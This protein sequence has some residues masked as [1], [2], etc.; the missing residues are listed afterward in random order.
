MAKKRDSEV[1]RGPV[2]VAIVG[3]GCA[4]IAAAWELSKV[5]GYEVEVFEKSW[6][7]GGKGASGRDADGH[8]QEHGLH[9]WLGFYENA[10]RMIR[11]CYAE[12]EQRQ[13][14][15]RRG[16]PEN[17]LAH[18]SWDDAF[19]AEPH[20]G[21]AIPHGGDEWLVW[22][23]LLPPSKGLPGD[24]FDEDSNPFTLANYLVRC[25]ELLRALMLS[26]IGPPDEPVPGKPRPEKRST[27][28][29]AMELNFAFD[30]ARSP[31]V[32]IET[33]AR[34]LRTGALA[35][36]AGLLQAVTILENWLH[37]MNYSPQVADTA[38]Q[39]ME[40]VVAQ[41]RKLLRDVVSVDQ[42][43]RWKTEIIDIVMTIAVGL[44]RDRVLFEKDGLD[45][46]NHIDYREWLRQHGA[47]KTAVESRFITGIYDLTFAYKDGDRKQPALAAGVALRGALRMFFTYRGSIFWRMRSGM[48]DA[49][50]APLYKVLDARGVK[51]HFRHE[52]RNVRFSFQPKGKRYVTQMTFA[53]VPDEGAGADV[54]DHFGC[55]PSKDPRAGAKREPERKPVTMNVKDDFDAVIFAMG[56]DD[57]VTVLSTKMDPESGPGFFAEMPAEWSEMQ[58]H[59]VTVATQAAQVWLKR[60]LGQLGWHRGSGIVTA[61]EPPFETWADMTHTLA[62]EKAWRRAKKQDAAATDKTRSVAY[63]CSV[64]PQKEVKADKDE[65]DRKVGKDLDD[66]LKNKIRPLWPAA[67]RDAGSAATLEITRHV[68]ANFEGSDRFTLSLP[69]SIGHRISPLDRSVLNMAIAGDWTAA[70][71]DAGCVETAVMSGMLAAFAIT[72]KQ[73]ALESI[74]GYDHP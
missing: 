48:G 15:P 13:W 53:T 30:P 66:L 29:E 61:F 3:G 49:V 1:D 31:T 50:F 43:L 69:G 5:E 19:L 55:W 40:A 39:L 36:A 67:F 14:G 51:F 52:L 21:V 34:Y 11:E 54:L 57:F 73:P 45:A 71:I 62:S 47:T 46:I 18:R 17:R 33:M 44:Y 64:L 37:K 41:T 10:F 35:T 16:E 22:S 32:V 42:E 58:R 56:V 68:Q 59:V 2:R 65:M 23:G 25:F 28:D 26:V 6:R 9:I 60:D 12:V 7:L 4:G 8:I 20:L 27:L 24:G 63:F 70:G 38:L 74:I 72:G